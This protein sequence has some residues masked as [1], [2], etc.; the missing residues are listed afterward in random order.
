VSKIQ[1]LKGILSVW[2]W[3]QCGRRPDE[4]ADVKDPGEFFF[5]S[6]DAEGGSDRVKV[7]MCSVEITFDDYGAVVNGAVE[8]L[9]SEARKLVAD[10]QKKATEL[11]RKAQ[12]ML[13]IA[14]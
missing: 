8:A 1:N 3:S 11:E 4:L 9:R 12:E 10:A 2:T 7:G 5:R 14:A 13:A 6:A